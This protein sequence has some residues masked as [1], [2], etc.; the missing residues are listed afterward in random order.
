MVH[1]Q[2]LAISGVGPVNQSMAGAATACPIDAAG[3]MMW[4]PAT[5]SGLATS[6]VSIGVG[7]AMPS[8]NLSSRIPAGSLGN[9][10]PSLPLAES[11]SS[12]AGFSAIPSIGFVE[13]LD[14]T[15]L[16]Y[17]LGVFGIGGFRVNY[18]ASTDNPV[19]TEQ[20]PLGLGIGRIFS[21]VEILQMAPTISYAVT[22][23]FSIGV[24]PTV[25]MA[26]I[27]ADPLLL[28]SPDD[29]NGDGFPSYPAGRGNR[30]KFRF[31]TEDELGRPRTEKFE[32]MYP[33]IV[34]LGTAYSGFDDIVFA[35]D[36]R[37]FDYGN[38]TGFQETG[39]N[40]DGSLAGLGWSSILAVS[41]GL[42]FQV[43]PGLFL[44]CGYSYN[45]N[46]ISGFDSGFNV[47][48]PVIVQHFAYFGGSLRLSKSSCF[49]VCYT[50]GFENDV[51]GP[52]QS[53]AGPIP[54]TL[55]TNEASLDA[56]SFGVTVNY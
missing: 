1:G 53:A 50:H 28:A 24:A 32:F 2:G 18:P 35:L 44:R 42:Q 16:S 37:L 19:L 39:F 8:S 26:K 45:Q 6:E 22:E 15:A 20:P 55:V 49:S 41:T 9:G 31:R 33:I 47:A 21:E 54:D 38:A 23:Q 46:P 25:T 10:V 48:S 43:R 14:C 30:V 4:N 13:R 17:G 11:D 29:A 51:A 3:A 56:V 36:M 5:I 34:T 27:S 52:I 40:P 12:E 7:L